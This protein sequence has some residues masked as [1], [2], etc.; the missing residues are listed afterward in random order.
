[1]V[2]DAEFVGYCPW[3]GAVEHF[4][5]PVFVLGDEE[6]G[7][8]PVC[9]VFLSCVAV[10]EV[11]VDGVAEFVGEDTVFLW[12]AHSVSQADLFAVVVVPAGLACPVVG[13]VHT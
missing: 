9:S 8:E 4:G 3:V 11:A 2:G 6:V 1:M 10:A 13:D 5:L 7:G 12:C